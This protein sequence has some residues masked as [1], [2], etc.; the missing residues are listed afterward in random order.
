MGGSSN[1]HDFPSLEGVETLLLDLGGVII[2]IEPERSSRAFSELGKGALL[3]EHS[4][5]EQDGLYDRFERGEISIEDFRRELK[6]R[7]LIEGSDAMIDEAWNALLL[8]IPR[9]RFH[10]L[11]RLSRHYRLHLFSNTNEVHMKGF[12]RIVEERYGFEAFKALFEG[13]H[14][15][16]E[17]GARKPEKEAFEKLLGRMGTLPRKVLFIDDTKDHVEAAQGIG[18]RAYH[19]RSEELLGTERLLLP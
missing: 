19:L 12:S 14:L 16:Y 7:A 4:K 17:M 9:E 11:E 5:A 18:I 15:S 13:I 2:D 3:L 8:D 1:Q 10:F 6:E